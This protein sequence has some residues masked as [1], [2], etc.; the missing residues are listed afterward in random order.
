MVLGISTI[1]HTVQHIKVGHS[2]YHLPQQLSF[3]AHVEH[4]H[5]IFPKKI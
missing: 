3:Y 4:E 5:I 2:S 1:V